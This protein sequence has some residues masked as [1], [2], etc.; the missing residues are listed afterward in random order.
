MFPVA[1]MVLVAGVASSQD[2][3][4]RPIRIFTGGV[5]GGTDIAARLV[6][7]GISGPLGQQVIIENRPSNIAPTVNLFSAF[8][9]GQA[10]R[11]EFLV[12]HR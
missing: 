3:P 9:Q 2:Y 4:N 6:A 10:A 11:W 7:Q 8:V 12:M 5:G 1:M